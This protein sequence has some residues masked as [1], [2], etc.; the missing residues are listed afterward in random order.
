MSNAQ[1][2]PF[3]KSLHEFGDVKSQDWL[4][5]LPQSIPATVTALM[6]G[7]VKV[8]IDGTWA[9]FNIPEILVPQSMSAWAREPTQVGD[10]GFV[11]GINY[12]VG[13][14]SGLGGGNANLYPRANLTNSVFQPISQKGFSTV[15]PNAYVLNGPNGVVLR[16][17]G[18]A[19]VLTLTPTGIVITIG[20]NTVTIDA[21]G[22]TISKDLTIQGNETVDGNLTVNGTFNAPGIDSAGGIAVPG[23]VTAMAGSGSSVG[24]A[25]HTTSGV[26][27][28]GGTSGAPTP[29]T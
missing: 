3:A 28:G 9:P 23:E 12:Y 17:T 26:T 24:L 25:S 27:A 16:D 5:R 8:K 29:G 7:L 18:G 22:V 2:T 10:K 20:A 4:S 15:D 6:G 13:G 21:S 14:Q 1:K 11:V 19:C